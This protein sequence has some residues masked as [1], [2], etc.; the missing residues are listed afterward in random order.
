MG[1]FLLL[2]ISKVSSD[3]I[4]QELLKSVFGIFGIKNLSRLDSRDMC[5]ATKVIAQGGFQE[6]TY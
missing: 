4:T 5:S 2:D 6:T 1:T 3:S